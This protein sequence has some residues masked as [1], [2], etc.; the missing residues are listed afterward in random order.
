MAAGTEPEKLTA[1]VAVPLHTVWVN[2]VLTTGMGLTV[3]VKVRVVPVQPLAV[4]V[5]DTSA[6]DTTEEVLIAVNDAILPVPL[7]ARPTDEF[8]FVQV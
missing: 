7:E 1:E 5:V 2:G 3:T 8:E 4:G 6:V